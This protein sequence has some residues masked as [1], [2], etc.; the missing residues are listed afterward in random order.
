AR[1]IAWR[2]TRV[3]GKR[4]PMLSTCQWCP[5]SV[6]RVRLRLRSRF[7]DRRGAAL[8]WEAFPSRPHDLVSAKDSCDGS[9]LFL[10]PLDEQQGLHFPAFSATATPAG[11]T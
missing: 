5:G 4:R 2:D 6:L 10:A 7:Q 1:A 9:P 11:A 8:A 3:L